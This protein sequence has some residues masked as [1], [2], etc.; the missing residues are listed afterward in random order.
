VRFYDAFDNMWRGGIAYHDFVICGCCGAI[1]PI[2]DIIEEANES[3]VHFDDAIKELEWID[4]SNEI[5][6]E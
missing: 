3:G 1:M 2:E 6:G 4:I 5:A